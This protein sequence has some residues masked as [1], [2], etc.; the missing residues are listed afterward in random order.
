MDDSYETCSTLIN[1]CY[2][3]KSALA[4]VPASIYCNKVM[5]E[6]YMRTGLNPYDVRMKCS[7]GGLCYN[8][9]E[10]IGKWLNSD[11]VKQELGTVGHEWSEVDETVYKKFFMTGDWYMCGACASRHI[12]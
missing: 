2:K 8:G 5:I 4:C 10:E 11:E 9:M 12:E 7:N 1:G 6:P 3:T